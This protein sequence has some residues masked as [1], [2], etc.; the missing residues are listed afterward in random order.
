MLGF[1]AHRGFGLAE[2]RPAPENRGSLKRSGGVDLVVRA[3]RESRGSPRRS[4]LTTGP[5]TRRASQLTV[6]ERGLARR[7]RQEVGPPDRKLWVRHAR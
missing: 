4:R 7:P 2:R 5:T 6:I 1:R 3:S